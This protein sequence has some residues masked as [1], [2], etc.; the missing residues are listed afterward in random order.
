[1]IYADQYHTL[2]R[3]SVKILTG[4]PFSSLVYDFSP[5]FIVMTLYADAFILAGIFLLFGQLIRPQQIY[6]RQVVTMLVGILVVQIGIVLSILGIVQPFQRDITPFTFAICNLIMAWGLFRYQLLDVVPIAHHMIIQSIT[7]AV[8]VLD[9]HRRII[10]M[11]QEAEK[12]SGTQLAEVVGKPAPEVFSYIPDI[13]EIL[14]NESDGFREVE[15][16][17]NGGMTTLDIK[18][19]TLYDQNGRQR[20]RVVLARDVSSV[21]QSEA[22]LKHRTAQLEQ[23]NRKL[24]ATNTRLHILSRAKDEFVSNVS[25]ELRT[26][27]SNLKLYI[28]LLRIRPENQARYLETLERETN[29]LEGMIESLLMLSRLDQDRVSFRYQAVDLNDLVN[30]Y[31]EDRRQLAASKGLRLELQITS[32]LPRVRADR[33][34]IGQVLSILLTNALNY[35]PEGGVITVTTQTRQ[36]NGH[37]WAGIS[38]K[39]TGRGI[40]EE[41]QKQLFTRF[42]RGYA[43]REAEVAGTGL[44]LAISKEII[45]RHQGNIEVNSLGVPGMGTQ[46][47]VWLPAQFT[48]EEPYE[49]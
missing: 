2:V 45:T 49:D 20:G 1:V 26:P 22:E 6:R 40:P 7:D 3:P 25:H 30:E 12:M 8:V 18:S 19:S 28:D 38:V 23:A 32:G 13:S 37:A 9:T 14:S 46:F 43:A 5:F 31:V 15:L 10:D 42:F 41:E 21:K 24:E 11:N 29:R 39:D 47:D 48:L 27:I 4:E 35:T 36:E 17:V 44:G 33:T 16:P 34:L